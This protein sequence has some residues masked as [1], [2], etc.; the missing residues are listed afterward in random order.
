MTTTTIACI[1]T[2][3][4][5]KA[6]VV[7]ALLS[8]SSISLVAVSSRDKQRAQTFVD[9]NCSNNTTNKCA[10]M[11]HDEVLEDTAID[12]VYVPLPSKVRNAF[13]AKALNNNKHIYSEKPFG[14]SVNELQSIL[15]MA[16][17]LNLQWIDGTMWYH[18]IRTKEMEKILY[19]SDQ[20]ECRHHLHGEGAA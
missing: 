9:E 1:S 19:N 15:D 18:S 3:D 17:K 13:I 16:K 12:A 5:A 4:I 6:K 20:Y 8:V 7:P 10:G 14:G 11:T 2:A